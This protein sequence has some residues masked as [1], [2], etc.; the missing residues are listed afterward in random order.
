MAS[1]YFF[2]DTPSLAVLSLANA[3]LALSIHCRF[4]EVLLSGILGR[5]LYGAAVV[6]STL[7]AQLR[8]L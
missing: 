2:G 1:D 6:D 7:S 3:A 5:G 4:V 8:E